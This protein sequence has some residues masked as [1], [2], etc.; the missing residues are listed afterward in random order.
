MKRLALLGASG[1]GKVVAEAA[2]LSG[3]DSIEFFDAAWPRLQSN[4]PWPVQGDDAAL[5]ER[6]SQYDGILV[7]IG[8]CAIRWKLH[9]V[10]QSAGVQFATVIHPA[11]TVSRYARLAPGTAVMAGA[12]VNIDADIGAA[13]IINTGATVDHDCT[14]EAAV[15]IGPGAHLSGN[16]Q[17]GQGAW[18]GVGSTVKQGLVVAAGAMVG[19]GAVVVHSVGAGITVIG[20]PARPRT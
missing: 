17:V 20:N 13:C 15:H 4:G 6:L 2:L 9:Q 10:L 3:W 7:S 19:A 14:L 1:H 18:I 16:V 12:V 11:A 8:N 5:M